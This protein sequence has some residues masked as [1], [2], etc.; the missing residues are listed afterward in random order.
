MTKLRLGIL[1]SHP[2]QYYSPWFRGLA[3]EVDLH[4]F[5]AHRQ[6]AQ[7][8][9]DAGFGVA[10]EW[11]IDLLGGYEHTFLRN[12]AR[13]P[14]VNRWSGC[15]T[16]EIAQAIAKEK[17]EVFIVCGWYLK[18]YWQALRAC[19]KSAIPVL[20]RGDSHLA[21]PRSALKRSLKQLVYRQMLRQFDGFLVTGRRNREYLAHYGVPERK[22]FASPPFV[23]ND[24]FAVRAKKEGARRSE[25][26]T[27]WGAG[28]ETLAVLFV[29]K[30]Q[31]LKRVGDILDALAL[32]R[33]QDIDA[34]AILVGAGDT[35]QALQAQAAALGIRA[36][37]EGFQN[38][39]SLPSYYAASD[40]LVLPSDS[41]TWGLVVNEAIASGLPAIVSDKVGCAPDLIDEGSTGFTFPA[42]DVRELAKRLN[43]MTKMIKRGHDFGPALAAKSSACSVEA[44]VRGTINAAQILR[45]R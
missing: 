22:M 29:G 27:A 28:D 6:S 13:T 8:Q 10:F 23:D 39:S 41:E 18:S 43:A 2:V 12:V 15:D 32:L 25:L 7:E 11:D 38:Q 37:F 44:A 21:T 9:S 33:G 20:V 17:C 45:Q 24:W 1:L 4:V 26:R 34:L 31:A 16:P 3:A 30:F 5:Y 14:N 42:G 40:V 19:R 35:E 36:L